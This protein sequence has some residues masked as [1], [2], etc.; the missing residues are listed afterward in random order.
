SYGVPPVLAS[1]AVGGLGGRRGWAAA[2]GGVLCTRGG[3]PVPTA[4]L[5]P[6]ARG[7]ALGGLPRQYML[8]P[9]SV[10][11][12]LPILVSPPVPEIVP[13]NAVLVLSLPVVSVAEPSVTAP[14][15]ASEPM[16]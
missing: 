5:D 2:C 15:P 16:V 11:V 6:P 12:P 14:A 13:E 7:R 8:L 1:F 3:S 10:S 9:E 4:R